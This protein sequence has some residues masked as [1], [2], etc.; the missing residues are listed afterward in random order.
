MDKPL[1][2]V[3]SIGRN[4]VRTLPRL[5]ESLNEFLSRGGDFVFVDTGSTDGTSEVAR[6]GGAKVF[7]VGDRFTTTIDDATANAINEKFVVPPDAPIVQAGSRFFSFADARNYAKGLAENDFLCTPDCDEAWTTLDIDAINE[8]IRQ[9]YEK[10]MVNFVFAHFPDGSPSVQFVADTR[11]YD[12]RK[13]WWKG[14]IHET[15][16][17]NPEK[18]MA[19]GSEVAYLEH[20]Q[21]QETDRSKYLSGL[22]WACYS[23]PDN[24]RNSHYFARELLYRGD[25][26]NSAIKE[27][28]RHIDMNKW[29]VERGQSM[30]YIG[31]CYAAVG[32]DD[33]ALQWW[34]RAIGSGETRR[35]A[36][37]ALA[38]YW[39]T[40]NKPVLVSAYAQAALEIP[41]S[42]FYANDMAHYT[43]MPY[44]F[45]YW[46]KGW[47][48]DIPA[49]RMYL[50]KCLEY[51][52]TSAVYLDHMQ[53]YFSKEEQKT[54]REMVRGDVK[55]WK[56]GRTIDRIALPIT[57]ACNRDCPECSARK[58]DPDWDRAHPHVSVDEL[59]WVGKTLGPIKTI[60][61]TGGEPSRHPEFK[62]ISEHFHDWFQSN[63]IMLLTNALE[64]YY[65]PEK[66]PLLLYYDRV[67]ISWYTNEFGIKYG[68]DPNTAAVNYVEDYLKKSGKKFWTQRMDQHCPIGKP[69]YKGIPT[70]GYDVG[71][72]V[73]YGAGKIYGCCT[74]YWLSDRGKGIPLT[75]DWRK[76]L[77]EIELPCAGCFLT[78]Q[79]EGGT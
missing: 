32:K 68:V 2:S 60:E 30:V 54:V 18:V 43:F 31:N 41:N 46:A 70:C 48:G 19:V 58:A 45:L 28:K 4:E 73:G 59:K 64:F 78:G 38:Q 10:L 72:S 79:E 55:K 26:Y 42:G 37:L 77:S 36:F 14:I 51:D 65:C 63:D 20:Y 8:L 9:G 23:E 15:Q 76:H 67:Y 57:R 39:K 62:E 24:D 47:R 49:A 61:V 34:H 13:I 22:A 21:N 75:E 12:R 17:G 40:K 5:I 33:D 29:D 44:E 74:A 16:Q 52:P 27:F 3:V 69:P 50:T 35:A 11:F 56:A 25:R 71:D 6:K 7:E 53:Y 66:L 1:F